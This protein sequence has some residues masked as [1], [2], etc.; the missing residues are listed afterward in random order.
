MAL[1]YP[2]QPLLAWSTDDCQ[3]KE[4]ERQ[5][6]ETRERPHSHLEVPHKCKMSI[7]PGCNTRTSLWTKELAGSGVRMSNPC[8]CRVG[9]LFVFAGLA[10]FQF[11][12][13]A[14]SLTTGLAQQTLTLPYRWTKWCDRRG[15]VQPC[16]V[17]HL[18]RT[19]IRIHAGQWKIQWWYS[20]GLINEPDALKAK[21]TKLSAV[22]QNQMSGRNHCNNKT[23]QLVLLPSV[24][25][26]LVYHFNGKTC[27][28]EHIMVC[29]DFRTFK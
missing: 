17:D 4:K 27:N 29:S 21:Q 3:L 2:S 15:K 12:T 8:K 11:Q 6:A 20:T 5:R 23:Q 26:I 7:S 19:T 14:K 9:S 18:K 16:T 1:K 24:K 28:I 13:C 25:V 10:E 22:L